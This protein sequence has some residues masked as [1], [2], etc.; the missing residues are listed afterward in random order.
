M[1][2]VVLMVGVACDNSRL[3]V[4]GLS[5]VIGSAERSLVA[6]G[7]QFFELD[8]PR[9][10]TP[11]SGRSGSRK[12]TLSRDYTLNQA[13]YGMRIGERSDDPCYL[14]VKWRNLTS[15][16]TST[17]EYNECD[18]SP[19][20]ASRAD[21]EYPPP[22]LVT[23]V[24]ACLNSSR[25]KLKGLQLLFSPKDCIASLSNSYTGKERQCRLEWNPDTAQLEEVCELVDVQRACT[26]DSLHFD[27]GYKERPN[28]VGNNRGPDD[29][30]EPERLCPSGQVAT[31]ITLNERN[32]GGNRE[33]FNGIRLI[34]H[35]VESTPSL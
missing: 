5:P 10:T 35:D 3:A 33:M 32:G 2:T 34:C 13:I 20:S 8:L 16:T 17:R 22:F 1:G 27:G 28:C 30:W 7:L 9:S 4:E 19:T 24:R 23:G 15:G 21:I 29:D 6:P 11:Y 12:V 26:P 31:G 25:T 14:Q 18:T